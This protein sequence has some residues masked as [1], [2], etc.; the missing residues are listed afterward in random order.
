MD[1]KLLRVGTIY[2]PVSDVASAAEWYTAKLGA[3]L[4]YQ[5]EDKAILDMANLSF[6]LVKAPEN[7]SS[8]FYDCNGNERFSFTF[9]VDGLGALTELRKEFKQRNIKTGEIEDR[10]H[11]GRNFVFWDTDG[12]KFD[13]WSELSPVFKERDNT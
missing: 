12:N 8:N 3:G 11:A 2:I 9:E 6:F 5:D 13:V 7:Q 4:N 1:G 10:G